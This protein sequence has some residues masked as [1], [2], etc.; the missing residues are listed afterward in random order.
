MADAKWAIR[1]EYM[2]SCNCDYLCPCIVTQMKVSTHGDCFR[3]LSAMA[4]QLGMARTSRYS[5]G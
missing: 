1:G 5:S 2:E 4:P 3:S